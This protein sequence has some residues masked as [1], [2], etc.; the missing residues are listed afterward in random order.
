MKEIPL[1]HCYYL[2]F[3]GHVLLTLLCERAHSND[4]LDGVHRVVS[5]NRVCKM[6]PFDH[7]LRR[8]LQVGSGVGHLYLGQQQSRQVLSVHVGQYIFISGQNWFFVG[9][10]CSATSQV[11]GSATSMGRRLCHVEET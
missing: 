10:K 6:Y 3:G 1:Y 7:V 2:L 4:K 5:K 9:H 11:C 8:E